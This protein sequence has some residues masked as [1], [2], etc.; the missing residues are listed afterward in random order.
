M[1]KKQANALKQQQVIE[2]HNPL[3]LMRYQQRSN[4]YLYDA[5]RQP[6]AELNAQGQ[7]MKQA[8]CETIGAAHVNEDD[9]A[10]SQTFILNLCLPGQY[11]DLKTGVQ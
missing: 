1:I 5:D 10:N 2:C 9:S 7:Q 6:L 4:Y 3:V 8:R 11:R